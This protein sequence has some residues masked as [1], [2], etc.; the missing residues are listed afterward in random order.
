MF[1]FASLEI[2]NFQDY[3]ICCGAVAAAAA[4]AIGDSTIA[5]CLW[6][7]YTILLYV[8]ELYQPNNEGSSILR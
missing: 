8:G 2:L 7:Q 5:S 4:A 6:Q 3:R 1:Q